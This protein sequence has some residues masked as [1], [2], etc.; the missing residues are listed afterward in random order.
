MG[1]G[2]IVAG[3][4]LSQT[5]AWYK[6]WFWGHCGY[7]VLDTIHIYVISL[8]VLRPLAT[9]LNLAVLSLI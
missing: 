8:P 3:Y 9:A 1:G 4:G 2:F 7:T 5:S 6:I